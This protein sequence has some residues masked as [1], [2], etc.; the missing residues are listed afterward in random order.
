MAFDEILKE[1][2]WEHPLDL[3]GGST[4]QTSPKSKAFGSFGLD[5]FCRVTAPSLFDS[6]SA[7][8]HF[9]ASF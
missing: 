4:K 3:C 1:L 6:F 7:K 9:F 5:F 8:S 2:F